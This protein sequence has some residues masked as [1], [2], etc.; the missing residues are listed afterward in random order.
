MLLYISFK[1][2]ISWS[3]RSVF[4]FSRLNTFLFVAQ[5]KVPD[6]NIG[7]EDEAVSSTLMQMFQQRTSR[8][9]RRNGQYNNYRYL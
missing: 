6:E 8:M 3:H 9:N 7:L 5:D 4:P 2:E 1:F